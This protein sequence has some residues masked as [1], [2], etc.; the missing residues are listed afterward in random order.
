MLSTMIQGSEQDQ[1]QSKDNTGTITVETDWQAR[2]EGWEGR[3]LFHHLLDV[4]VITRAECK[5]EIVLLSTVL[6]NSD[7]SLGHGGNTVGCTSSY[8][9]STRPLGYGSYI[10]MGSVY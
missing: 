5:R 10:N 7:H 2:E 3:I 8:L 9:L 6:Q 4:Y 1:G